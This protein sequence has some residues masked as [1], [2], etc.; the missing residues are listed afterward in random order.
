MSKRFLSTVLAIIKAAGVEEDFK[1]AEHF[2]IR[3]PNQPFMDVVIESWDSPILKG[4]RHISVAHYIKM[5]GDLVADPEVE[6]LD[7][8]FP[9][10]LQQVL[11]YTQVAEFNENEKLQYYPNRWSAV[12]GFLNIWS[13]NLRSQEFT[14]A[15]KNLKTRGKHENIKENLIYI[16][17]S[18]RC[19]GTLPA[20][21]CEICG[22]K[23]PEEAKQERVH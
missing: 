18:C 22:K 20:N 5:N 9:I 17:P 23:L 21:Y 13:K 7:D 10:H 19:K 12:C 14:E 16:C 11:L 4:R 8:G 1:T 6:I 2:H 15:A 3:I